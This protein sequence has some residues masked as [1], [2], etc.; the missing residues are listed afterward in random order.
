MIIII[1]I[2]TSTGKPNE[3]KTSMIRNNTSLF[4]L[5]QERTKREKRDQ[6]QKR[7]EKSEKGQKR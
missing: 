2:H 1:I 4:H 5:F 6:D 3:A 7:V